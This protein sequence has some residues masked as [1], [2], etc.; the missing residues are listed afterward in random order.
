M[1]SASRRPD[2]AHRNPDIKRTVPWE[3]TAS[4]AL[5]LANSQAA[6]SAE[7]IPNRE[8]HPLETVAWIETTALLAAA[9]S[10]ID[11]K[12]AGVRYRGGWFMGLTYL[13]T[14][15]VTPTDVP[16][17]GGMTLGYAL[18]SLSAYNFYLNSTHATKDD[19]RKANFWG[20]NLVGGAT[21]LAKSLDSSNTAGGRKSWSFHPVASPDA[22]GL[23][24]MYRF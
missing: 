20:V 3:V 18:L 17:S 6:I 19:L 1:S 8:I 12:W 7:S 23:A 21:W 9:V 14:A 16:G 22:V 4:F 24:A 15:L 11:F 5:L 2:L 13:G 10:G